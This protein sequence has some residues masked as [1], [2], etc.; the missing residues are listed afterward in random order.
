MKSLLL[1]LSLVG[2]LGAVTKEVVRVF[3]PLSFHDTDS[4]TEFGPEG[5]LLQAEVVALPMV[6]SGAFPEDLVKAVS[7]PHQFP[8]NNPD[9]EVSEVNMLV[10]CGLRLEVVREAAKLEILLDCSEMKTPEYLEVEISLVIEM[11][12][13]SLRRTLRLYYR[14]GEHEGF[15][16]HFSLSGLPEE[17][18]ELKK[19]ETSFTVGVVPQLETEKEAEAPPR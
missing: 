9:Y 15:D 12:V 14:D 19:L 16:C 11:V 1:V 2:S 4:A 6:L 13:E 7:K 18:G 10:L 5:K 17:A 8:T 3:Q